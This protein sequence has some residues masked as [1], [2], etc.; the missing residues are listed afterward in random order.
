MCIQGAPLSNAEPDARVLQNRSKSQ[1]YYWRH[2]ETILRNRATRYAEKKQNGSPIRKTRIRSDNER[3]AQAQRSRESYHRNRDAILKRRQGQ[4][5][6]NQES[7]STPEGNPSSTDGVISSIAAVTT[8]S[9][10]KEKEKQSDKTSL[11]FWGLLDRALPPEVILS[12]RQLEALQRI[13]DPVVQYIERLYLRFRF[14]FR[15]DEAYHEE[16]SLIF[17]D[18]AEEMEALLTQINRCSDAILNIIGYGKEYERV[19]S[20]AAQALTISGWVSELEIEALDDPNGLIRAHRNKRL[21][22]QQ[23]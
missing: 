9:S 13:T 1:S 22:Y 2:R 8:T 3:A 10:P 19:N 12:D 18:R 20:L 6:V 21:M 23:T 4:R 11:A 15:R 7:A 5:R 14:L 16:D 17:Q